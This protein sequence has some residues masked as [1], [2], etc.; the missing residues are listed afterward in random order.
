[1]SK[2]SVFEDVSASAPEPAQRAIPASER[3]PWRRGI[4][5][6]LWILAGFVVA[7]I[8]VGGATR[9]TDSGLSITEW[10]PVMGSI[11][12]LSAGD[13]DAAF[14][15]YKTTT[16]YQEQ[17]AWMTL[18]DFKPIY[19]WEW[20]HRAL[21][22][23]VGI[24][25]LVGF[26]IF[27]VA[28]RIPAGWTGRLFLPGA[29]GGLQ[30]AIGWWMVASGLQ[31]R[32]DVAP[33]RLAVHLGLAFFIFALLTW[34][35]L[36][37]RSDEVATLQARRRRIGPVMGW[38]TVVTGLVF[39]QILSGALVAGLDAGGGYIDWPLMEGAFLPP[40]SFDLEPV[41]L[42][43]FENPA[44]AQFDHRMLAYLLLVATFLF[45]MRAS[46]A[47]IVMVRRTA[48]W[49][50]VVLLG[51]VLLGIVTVM[52]AAPLH[53]ALAHQALAV[54]LVWTLVRARFTAAYP[55]EQRITADT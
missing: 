49:A 23:V 54:L 39:V 7:M 27:A 14:D 8:L 37:V 53:F 45:V 43:I 28:R 9:L 5:L 51:Q 24:V 18:A 42:N 4:A 25:W 30:G 40:E 16:E 35:A 29:L 26:L 48:Q 6:W 3:G 11:P 2:R 55:P 36:R 47:G 1:M 46:R 52:H 50:G 38:T 34:Y 15:A 32:L 22:R 44:L 17:N 12:P 21:G 33:Y 41:W 19:W 13:W 31:D 10:A 20:G